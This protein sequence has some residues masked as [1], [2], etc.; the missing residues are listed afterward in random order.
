MDQSIMIPAQA[1]VDLI[2]PSKRGGLYLVEVTGAK[3]N[4]YTMSYEIF[5]NGEAHAAM[6]GLSKFESYVCELLAEKGK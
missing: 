6:E 5:A 3:P 1:T 4:D 2:R